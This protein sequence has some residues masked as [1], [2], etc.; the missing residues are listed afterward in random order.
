MVTSR[1]EHLYSGHTADS[2]L[3]QRWFLRCINDDFLIFIMINFGSKQSTHKQSNRWFFIMIE[4]ST[5][6]YKCHVYFIMM[7]IGGNRFYDKFLRRL[8]NNNF[9]SFSSQH[10][11]C[12]LWLND[13]IP[14]S[15]WL[16]EIQTFQTGTARE[17]N[18]ELAS[19]ECR[20]G[21]IQLHTLIGLPLGLMNC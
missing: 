11:H 8:F 2:P 9:N 3:Y 1:T 19:G 14:P 5:N 18:I 17:S 7:N 6:R 13:D 12:D 10:K 21:Q 4:L 15:N 16:L 20:C